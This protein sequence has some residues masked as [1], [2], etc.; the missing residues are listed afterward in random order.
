MKLDELYVTAKLAKL[1]LN[2]GEAE[3]LAVE[4]SRMLEYFSVMEKVDVEGLEA[5]VQTLSGENVRRPDVVTSRD[6]TAKMLDNVPKRDDRF[7]II[8]NVL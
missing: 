1:D 3:K 2:E 8:P 7:I 6:V 4:V 5:T